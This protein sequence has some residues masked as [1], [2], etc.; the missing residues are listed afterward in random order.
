MRAAVQ[1]DKVC[2]FRAGEKKAE[3][4][5]ELSR[6]RCVKAKS[7]LELNEV[8]LFIKCNLSGTA[9]YLTRLK[10]YHNL[11]GEFCFCPETGRYKL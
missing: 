5:V 2:S 3:R 8:A 11:W 10:D 6:S 9:G 4:Q 1:D 7:L